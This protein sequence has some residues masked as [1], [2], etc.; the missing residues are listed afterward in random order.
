M[1]EMEKAMERDG[2]EVND[3]QLACARIHSV[4]GQNY[5]AGKN[6]LNFFFLL[7]F[8]HLKLLL[9]NHFELLLLP[10]NQLKL[11]SLFNHLKV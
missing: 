8:N 4:E 10:F 3:R 5:L 6:H 9:F 2:I 11:L 7:L 1:Q